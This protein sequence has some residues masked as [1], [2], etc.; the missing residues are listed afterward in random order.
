MREA[1]SAGET[2]RTIYAKNHIKEF[3]E[4]AFCRALAAALDSGRAEIDLF[5]AAKI[6]GLKQPGS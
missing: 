4:A 2:L 5:D 1:F 6:A 3:D